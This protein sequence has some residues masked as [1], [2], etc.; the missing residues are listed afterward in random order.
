MDDSGFND[1]LKTV[2]EDGVVVCLTAYENLNT[3]IYL[4][5]QHLRC[6]VE[7]TRDNEEYDELNSALYAFYSSI[8]ASRKCL[9]EVG[10][11]VKQLAKWIDA[12]APEDDDDDEEEDGD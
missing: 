10:K 7:D 1:T 11:P 12:R 3:D 2:V 8:S 6:L 9:L 4:L 5:L